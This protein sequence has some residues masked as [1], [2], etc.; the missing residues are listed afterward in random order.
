MSR[1]ARGRGGRS[2]SD[3]ALRRGVGVHAA[4]ESLPRSARA[5]AAARRRLDAGRDDRRVGPHRPAGARVMSRSSALRELDSG[6]SSG[7]ALD[8]RA[9]GRSSARPLGWLAAL[10][11]RA[12][13]SWPS[14]T[15]RVTPAPRAWRLAG[16]ALR[17]DLS[18]VFGG[19]LTA[20]TFAAAF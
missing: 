5:R 7:P 2:R 13:H 9:P 3:A 4:R 20:G 19:L 10:D 11:P 15:L 1:A 18:C 16:V 8:S 14:S 6:H 17:A 12:T